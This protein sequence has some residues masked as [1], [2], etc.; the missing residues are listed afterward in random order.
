[1]KNLEKYNNTRI[2]KNPVELSWIG[3]QCKQT[4]RVK[5]VCDAKAIADELQLMDYEINVISA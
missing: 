5:S 1:M 2:D 3:G 4:L